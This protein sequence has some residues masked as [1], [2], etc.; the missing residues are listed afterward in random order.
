MKC[1][2]E[3]DLCIQPHIC[4]YVGECIWKEGSPKKHTR[5]YT[6]QTR[7]R[8]G[9]LYTEKNTRIELLV[10]RG[11]RYRVRRCKQCQ[12]DRMNAYNARKRKEARNAPNRD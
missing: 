4:G 12:A 9:H 7:C 6:K 3:N 2:V 5:S 10:Q 8:R 11:K 1:Y